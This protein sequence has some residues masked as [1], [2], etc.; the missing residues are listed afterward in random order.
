[1]KSLHVSLLEKMLRFMAKTVLWKYRP[2]V[3]GITGSVGKSSTKEAIALVLS[4]QYRVRKNEGNYNNEIGLPL[5]ILGR[6]TGGRS[7]WAWF[8]IIVYWLR[9]LLLPYRY[10]EILVLE[11][12]I[13]AKGDMDY[14]LTIIPINIGVATH[15]SG[16]HLAQFG[17]IANVAREKRKLIKCVPKTGFAILNA[18][19]GETLKMKD[20]TEANVITYG[21][22]QVADIQVDNLL[23][24][25]D[26]GHVEGYSFKLN[27]KGKSVPVRLPFILAKHLISSALAAVGVG[28]A[29]KMNLVEI[30]Q[31]LEGLKSLPGRMNMFSGIQGTQII[32]DTYNASPTST[33][34]AIE[35]LSYMQAPRKVAILGDMLELGENSDEEHA[36]LAEDLRQANVT[37]VLL[38]G[39]HMQALEEALLGIGYQNKQVSWYMDPWGVLEVLSETLHP[40]DLILVKGSQGLRMEFIV[41]ALLAQ[42]EKAE[43]LLCRQSPTW[44]KIPF[45]QPA[46]WSV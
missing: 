23:F 26:V 8:K 19:N 9:L 44:K 30:A 15:V 40:S 42:P 25:G 36:R 2:Q 28:V 35:T 3:I 7:L 13:D 1:M 18:D 10:P 34:A 14:L 20:V 5:T 31:A 38:V 39:K 37:R 12:G 46:E 27:Y 32:D 33:R 17:S 6:K 41:E 21:F 24:H 22:S 45:T 11:M 16:S 29:M 43:S 4:A